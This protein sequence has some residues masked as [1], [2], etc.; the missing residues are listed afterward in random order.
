MNIFEMLFAMSLIEKN[1]QSTQNPAKKKKINKQTNKKF[2]VHTHKL[3]FKEL[4]FHVLLFAQAYMYQKGE[5]K[6]DMRKKRC[7]IF[8]CETRIRQIPIGPLLRSVA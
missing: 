6:Q 2:K 8:G 4:L 7:W 1:P 3:C 5:K